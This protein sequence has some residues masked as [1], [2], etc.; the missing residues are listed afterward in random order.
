MELTRKPATPDGDHTATPAPHVDAPPIAHHEPDAADA[1]PAHVLPGVTPDH[2]ALLPWMDD[3]VQ[4]AHKSGASSSLGASAP[5][6]PAH[7]PTVAPSAPVPWMDAIVNTAHAAGASASL[8]A[9]GHAAPATAGASS[10][11]ADVHHAESNHDT[12]THADPK[13]QLADAKAN[14]YS[15]MLVLNRGSV[16][17]P[18]ARFAFL[19][20]LDQVD[21]P[22]VRHKMMEKFQAATGQSL[23]DFVGH[24]D[25]HGG[26][27]KEQ[28]LHMI[29]AERDQ[30]EA[31]IQA[32]TPAARKELEAKANGWAQRVL[33]VTRTDD[34]DSD[35]AAADIF[36]TLGSRSPEEVEAIRVAVQ[37]NT[38]GKHSIYEELDRSLSGGTEDEAVAG[39]SGDPVKAAWAGLKNVDNNPE[40]SKEIL[41]G[42]T[43]EQRVK[44]KAQ[45]PL[46]GT[47]WITED[48][49][50]PSDR[51]ELEDLIS[52]DTVKAEGDHLASLLR[53]PEDG[54][55]W[56]E[57][58]RAGP[59]PN[60]RNAEIQKER[61][62]ANVVREFESKSPEE[63]IAAKA[64]WDRDAQ[65]HGEKSWDA[66]LAARFGASD[67]R[68]LMRLQALSRGDRVESKALGFRE[69][70][71]TNNQEEMERVLASPDLT[72]KDPAKKAAAELERQQLAAKVK[73][74]DEAE[75]Y[76]QA[77]MSGHAPGTIEVAGRDISKQ[78]DDHYAAEAARDVTHGAALFMASALQPVIDKHAVDVRDGQVAARELVATGS[79]STATDVYRAD[80]RG[81]AD[82]KLGMLENLESSKQLADVGKDYASKYGGK[83]M[84][85]T[86]AISEYAT[87]AG[88]R[89]QAGDT[90]PLEEIEIELARD[91]MTSTQLRYDNLREYGTKPERRPDVE[92]RLQR[93]LFEKQHSDSLESSEAMRASF[94]GNVG[95]EDL[96][97]SQLQATDAMLEPAR[98]PFNVLPR[99]LKAGVERSEFDQIDKNLTGTLEV[100]REEKKKLSE[101][102]A[103]A[104][105]TIA[106]I[107]SM[108]I[109][110]PELALLFDLAMG[111]GKMGLQKSIEGDDFD[112]TANLEEMS[113]TLVTDVL[114]VGAVHGLKS[115][116]TAGKAASAAVHG[117]EDAARIGERVA[118]DAVDHAVTAEVKAETLAQG[119]DAVSSEASIT[120]GA[121]E[122]A[123][124]GPKT[125]RAAEAVSRSEAEVA[126]AVERDLPK[127]RERAETSALLP[128]NDVDKSTVAEVF[129]GPNLD[130]ARDLAAKHPGA[131]MIA[132]EATYLPSASDI[133][134][135]ER[136]GHRFVPDRFA[137]SLPP[138]SLDDV[139]ARYP[140][141]QSKGFEN[142]QHTTMQEMQDL[143]K[144]NPEMKEWEAYSPA[145]EAV[146]GRV[147]S[148]ANLGPHALEKLKVNGEFDIVLW[149]RK[150]ILGEV[151]ALTQLVHVD[152]I[153]GEKF[154]FVIS[155]EPTMVPKV[156]PA[157][158]IPEHI[159]EVTHLVLRK[160]PL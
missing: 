77:L 20:T 6:A 114:M 36:R 109:G 153:S 47:G 29:S 26:R 55:G 136:E 5:V 31:K 110:Q 68:T 63:L 23:Q 14:M 35:T 73:A 131:Q 120:R 59:I 17:D 121:E 90:R 91:E 148:V 24:A 92:A 54:A 103:K 101:A 105:S 71:A 74:F 41:R 100:Q 80:K 86:V 156:P 106:M 122:T 145:V 115:L 139:Y 79:L 99:E 15:T 84:L 88:I 19:N 57:A 98:D 72:S 81:D 116:G 126:E 33:A 45:A 60:I 61:T 119:L 160:V 94:G 51:A 142:I 112:A 143:L 95:T 7:A 85:K 64:A 157:F 123:H 127:P 50:N 144:A 96:A 89:K 42:L 118:V 30:A 129:T 97:R 22:V 67:P 58:M 38:A 76:T 44:F 32:M 117:T 150:E 149:E 140:I 113:S 137:E 49:K 13:E 3:F 2:A 16:S 82:A 135:F 138:S 8:V 87:I 48:V 102:T 4:T 56:Q 9:P 21:D 52:G 53:R 104:F 111:L 93:E 1:H 18:K 130:S 28:A 75:R 107:G 37:K 128:R 155:S 46:Y 147:E 66:M 152:P 25:W 141:P 83:E 39:L 65:A 132:A 40:R 154:R 10:G 125:T 108:V 151:D 133:E 27:D 159:T 11:H 34:A 43:P 62:P 78:V 124:A 12:T 134:Q 70:V 158:G 69:A 146:Q